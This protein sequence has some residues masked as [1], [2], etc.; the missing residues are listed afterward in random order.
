M[1]AKVFR[2][3]QRYFSFP[4]F[5]TPLGVESSA[6]PGERYQSQD[7]LRLLPTCHDFLNA[8]LSTSISKT[9]ISKTST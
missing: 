5:E 6:F 4:F 8:S 3:H 1:R 7:A 2:I 9:S